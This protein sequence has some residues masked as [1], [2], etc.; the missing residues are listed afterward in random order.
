MFLHS[1]TP[2]T[3]ADH[4]SDSKAIIQDVSNN[5]AEGRLQLLFSQDLGEGH[6]EL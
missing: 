2:H 5:D 6:L 1:M 3:H 4:L